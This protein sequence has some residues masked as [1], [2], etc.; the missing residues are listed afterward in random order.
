MKAKLLIGLIVTLMVLAPFVSGNVVEAFDR[1][2]ETYFV[3]TGEGD[4]IKVTETTR[5][6]CDGTTVVHTR[7][8]VVR[9]CDRAACDSDAGSCDRGRR[10]T[11]EVHVYAAS[12]DN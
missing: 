5:E 6:F 2:R 10:R 9:D 3:H 12:C 11:H 7:S 1:Y 8:R 4:V